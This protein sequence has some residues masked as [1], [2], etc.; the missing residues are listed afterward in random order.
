MQCEHWQHS[1]AVVSAVS[2][3]EVDPGFD[4]SLA[5]FCIEVACSPFISVGSLQGLQLPLRDM[6]RHEVELN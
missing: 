1:A 5:L 6:Q 4:S 2:S 3:Q